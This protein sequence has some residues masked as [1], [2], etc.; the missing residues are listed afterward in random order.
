MMPPTH[1]FTRHCIWY[2]CFVSFAE[3]TD[4]GRLQ[5]M[6]QKARQ[7]AHWVLQK[8]IL[9]CYP[10]MP[11]RTIRLGGQGKVRLFLQAPCL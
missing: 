11:G 10:A 5:T 9:D 7:D 8:V 4:T 2:R 3:E 6:Y 1:I